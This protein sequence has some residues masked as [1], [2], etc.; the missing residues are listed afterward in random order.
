MHFTERCLMR[1]FSHLYASSR[2]IIIHYRHS[3]GVS[4][5]RKDNRPWKKQP[6]H[7]LFK[8][9]PCT[10]DTDPGARDRFLTEF[11]ACILYYLRTVINF[12]DYFVGRSNLRWR[13]TFSFYCRRRLGW[14]P[15]LRKH[16]LDAT[17]LLQLYCCWSDDVTH[18]S[19]SLIRSLVV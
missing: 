15:V 10:L 19:E 11:T 2:E 18:V 16:S 13:L 9:A 3:E 14:Q 8:F 1:N 6:V 17:D 5:A 7:L 4:R 12:V